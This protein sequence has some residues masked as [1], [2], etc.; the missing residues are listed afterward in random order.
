MFNLGLG[1]LNLSFESERKVIVSPLSY[2]VVSSTY[3]STDQIGSSIKREKLFI[4]IKR[5]EELKWNTVVRHII[6]FQFLTDLY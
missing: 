3:K 5:T 4:N 1:V 6:H 2:N